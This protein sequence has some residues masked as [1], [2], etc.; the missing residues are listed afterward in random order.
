MMQPT[1]YTGGVTPQTSGTPRLP[2]GRVS[3][4]ERSTTSVGQP[5]SQTSAAP[6]AG[7]VVGPSLSSTPYM[8]PSYFARPRSP[9][10]MQ[11][12]AT[13]TSAQAVLFGGPRQL[14][15]VQDD[16]GPVVASQSC[17]MSAPSGHWQ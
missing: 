10:R 2:S 3:S 5:G 16:A 13:S 6:P 1:A 4:P 12:T 17:Q 8:T 11:P 9:I 15:L 7:T 14:P